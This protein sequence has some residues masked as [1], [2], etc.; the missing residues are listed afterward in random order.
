MALEFGITTIHQK[1]KDSWTQML[2]IILA[3]ALSVSLHHKVV[4]LEGG[5]DGWMAGVWQESH[6]WD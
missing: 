3:T 4:V 6:P 5:C 1:V 2:F